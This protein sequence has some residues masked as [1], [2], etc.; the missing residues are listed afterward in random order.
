MRFAHAETLLPV[1]CLI[2]LF[3]E[4]SGE[5]LYS[6]IRIVIGSYSDFFNLFLI[7]TE[8]ELIQREESLELPPKPP[9]NRNWRGSIMPPFAGNNMLI[10][11]S[12]QLDNSSNYF[13]QVL[14]N[15][16]PIALPVSVPGL[17]LW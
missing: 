17:I 12:C 3:L 6:R 4:E 16:R 8:F 15:E 11:Y 2:G 14:H 1:S 7:A 13:V 9:K 5:C 10:L